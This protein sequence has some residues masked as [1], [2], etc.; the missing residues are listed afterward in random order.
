MSGLFSSP[1]APDPYAT[2]AAQTAANEQ[3]AKTTAQYNMIDQYTPYGNLN[4]TQ[5][6]S[7]EDGTP[8]YAATQ[9]LNPLQQSTLNNQ[10]QL[11]NN[12]TG[13]GLNY[14]DL[15]SNLS[16]NPF[17][18]DS[19]GVQAPKGDQSYIDS[20]TDALYNQYSSRL[21]NKYG[22]EQS[23]LDQKLYNQGIAPGTDAW[24]QATKNFSLD[25]NDAYQSALNQSVANGQTAATNQ[26]NMQSNAYQNA[27]GNS[28]TVRNQPI[29]ELAALL[30]NSSG[31]QSP[32]L[33]NTPTTNVAGTDISGLIQNNYAT[34]QGASNA[35]IAALGQLAGAASSAAIM[36]D[37]RLKTNIRKIGKA[38]NGLNVYSFS[39]KARPDKTFV[40]FMAQDVKKFKP[41]AVSYT[42]DGYMM[43]DYNQVGF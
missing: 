27:L 18:T 20:A 16:K 4:Y 2:A 5:Q 21:D 9:T 31:V 7:Y 17:S 1:K 14:S 32:T 41:S 38:R 26:Y 12:I 35:K 34:K 23:A 25:K 37:R 10:D 28:L 24:N 3:T 30:G 15:F 42:N 43:V 39:Y 22:Q 19:L 29:N 8:K 11:S 36:S 33:T 40:G 6:G 13:I